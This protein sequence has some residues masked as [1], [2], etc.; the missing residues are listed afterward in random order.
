MGTRF[1]GKGKAPLDRYPA[2][3]DTVAHFQKVL[4]TIRTLS[5]ETLVTGYREWGGDIASSY[6]TLNLYDAGPPPNSTSVIEVGKPAENGTHFFPLEQVG[7]CMQEGPDGNT[8]VSF[9]YPTHRKLCF[10]GL[11]PLHLHCVYVSNGMELRGWLCHCELYVGAFVQL[12]HS[13]LGDVFGRVTGTLETYHSPDCAGLSYILVLPSA[14]WPCQ[15]VSDLR[16]LA[17]PGWA[18]RGEC[19]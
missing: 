10:E 7:I 9:S 8:N 11:S 3:L 14:C 19:V 1:D 15:R 18:R 6:Q 13:R 5:P 12:C 16:Q 4:D 17:P 2:G